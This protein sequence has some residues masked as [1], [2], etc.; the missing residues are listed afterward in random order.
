MIMKVK[1]HTNWLGMA[2]PLTIKLNG[3][4]LAKSVLM[5]KQ[6]LM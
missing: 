2:L 3:E 4:K 5:K 1:R 6:K